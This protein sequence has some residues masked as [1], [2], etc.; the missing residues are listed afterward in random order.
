M[1]V[2]LRN[3]ALVLLIASSPVYSQATLALEEL[4]IEGVKL[5]MN[6]GP[7]DELPAARRWR[8]VL[9]SN[10]DGE[11]FSRIA[12]RRKPA[13]QELFQDA[14]FAAQSCI[15]RAL[16]IARFA[17]RRAKRWESNLV[18]V[19]LP[20]DPLF[21]DLFR[22]YVPQPS[23]AP[24]IPKLPLARGQSECSAS[25]LDIV[26]KRTN[27]QRQIAGLKSLQFN[28][29]L[30]AAAR[31]QSIKTASSGVLSHDGWFETLQAFGYPGGY[32][33]QNIASGIDAAITVV[34]L[35]LT[36]PDHK[37]NLLSSQAALAGVGC[38][39]DPSG[40]KWWT[41]NYGS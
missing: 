16:L 25:D 34:D 4:S 14:P 37:K 26:I 36:S 15:Y 41:E 9:F 24:N 2:F 5:V 32:M 18:E 7:V 3:I 40:K 33:A 30:Q 38:V 10:C 23:P 21:Q 12:F 17:G 11:G 19:E 39:I 29:I 31:A 1:L 8:S 28:A 20:E 22:T 13:A 27:Y 35:W 6:I